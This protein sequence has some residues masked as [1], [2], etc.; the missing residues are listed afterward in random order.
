MWPVCWA[1]ALWPVLAD[2]Y[3]ANLADH[4][5]DADLGVSDGPEGLGER[6]ISGPEVTAVTC[7]TLG[8]PW[9]AAK[10]GETAEARI[11]RDGR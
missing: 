2:A 8:W 6:V 3:W 9:I 10:Q 1:T 4:A 7:V 11:G 5:G